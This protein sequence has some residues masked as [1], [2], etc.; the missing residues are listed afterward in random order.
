MAVKKC[1]DIWEDVLDDEQ[2]DQLVEEG[3]I[4]RV[5]GQSAFD[6]S[7]RTLRRRK[8]M[9]SILCVKKKVWII[10]LINR[11]DQVA[12]IRSA[13]LRLVIYEAQRIGL[14]IAA[15][16]MAKKTQRLANMSWNRIKS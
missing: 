13:T 10:A 12:Q 15:Y 4:E 5:S 9:M 2:V 7:K 1:S 11:G 6:L 3:G 8:I 14:Q 16:L